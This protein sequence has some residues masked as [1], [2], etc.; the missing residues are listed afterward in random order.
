MCHLNSGHEKR[1]S[2]RPGGDGTQA[3][4]DRG[5]KEE[6]GGGA[7]GSVTSPIQEGHLEVAWR[8]RA[9]WDFA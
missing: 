7:L 6:E 3:R 8:P 9:A 1:L 2:Q 4:A 5:D